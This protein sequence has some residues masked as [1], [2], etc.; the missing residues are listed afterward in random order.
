MSLD[1]SSDTNKIYE[2]NN[3]DKIKN[4]HQ[5]MNITEEANYNS[6]NSSTINNESIYTG[7]DTVS[8]SPSSHSSLAI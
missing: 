6:D 8:V 3:S 4:K 7:S 5:A 2:M 1:Q